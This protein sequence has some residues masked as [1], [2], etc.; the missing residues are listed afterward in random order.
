MSSSDSFARAFG[1]PGP[2]APDAAGEVFHRYQQRLVA[3][4]R[5]RLDARA[6]AKVDPDDVVQ[7]VYKSFFRRQADGQ[8]ELHGWDALWAVLTRITLCKCSNCNEFF[9][10]AKRDVRRE[11]DLAA[12]PDASAVAWEAPSREPTPEEA[13]LLA[14]TVE[15]LMR[16]LA[17]RDRDVLTL[18]L[19]GY[20][21]PEIGERLGR[22]ERTVR[23]VRERIEAR[24]EEMLG[25][26]RQGE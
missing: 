15:D 21:S 25:R 16:H 17:E 11:T 4:A 19:Q 9:G 14:E 12:A 10:A 3:L 8:F 5:G 18:S 26:A 22:A 7:S 13:A 23:R 6:R 24:L 1:A 20:S 2:H